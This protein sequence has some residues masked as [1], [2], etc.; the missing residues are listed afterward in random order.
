MHRDL[1]PAQREADA[2]RQGQGARLRP[3]Q[4]VDAATTP[5]SGSAADLSQSPTLAHTGTAAGLILGT[6]A[7]M[8]PEQAR[9]RAGRQAR[10]H[11]G[12]RRPAVRDAHRPAALRGRDGERRARRGAEDRARLDD[13]ARDDARVACVSCS[14]AASSATRSSGCA[15]SGKRGW[16]SAERR[17][18]PRGGGG[19][20]RLGRGGSRRRRGP[21]GDSRA[22]RPDVG[23]RRHLAVDAPA[24]GAA[25]SRDAAGDRAASGSGAVGKRRARDLARWPHARVHGAG[26]HRRRAPLPEGARPLRGE[27]RSRER[28]RP[29]ALLLTGRQPGRL[30]RAGEAADGGGRGRRADAD[31]RRVLPPPRRHLGRGRHDR[32][33]SRVERRTAARA[34]V[35]RQAPAA[36]GAGRGGS[37][38]RAR[39]AAV[40]SRRTLA[41]L[42]DLGCL[43]RRGAWARAAVAREGYVDSRRVRDLVRSLRPLRS[44]PALGASRHP[45]RALRPRSSATDEPPDLRRGRGVLDPGLVRFLVRGLGHGDA[46]VRAGRYHAR[47]AGLGRAGWPGEPRLRHASCRSRT[48]ASLPTARGSR[49]RIGT[50]TSGRWIFAA[51]PGSA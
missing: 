32:V 10:R 23:G 24:A 3:R 31:R 35:G 13:A 40:P 14:A 41:A 49:S 29:G 5:A 12:L 9:G 2:R 37:G 11:L 20:I 8:S 47:Q 16:P 28:G 21:L 7:Y 48:P 25:A 15:T 26:C 45:G 18:A 51:E 17:L 43:E 42:H 50:T 46:R 22:R 39:P 4:G 44:P 27:C 38:L 36:H 1:K 6:A 33:R 34:G 30:L 19:S